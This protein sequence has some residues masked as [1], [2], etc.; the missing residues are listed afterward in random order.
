MSRKTVLLLSIVCLTVYS[1]LGFASDLPYKPGEL[2]V[3]FAPKATGAQRTK[4]EQNEV[5]TSIDGGNIKHFYKLVPGLTV[6]KLPANR[7]VDK[8][9]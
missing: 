8:M 1:S 9:A 6:V 7:T 2:I 3:R 5:L 4:A